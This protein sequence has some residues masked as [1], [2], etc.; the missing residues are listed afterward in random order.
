MLSTDTLRRAKVQLEKRWH[1]LADIVAAVRE[2]G[3]DELSEIDA[4]LQATRSL[5][6]QM[7]K[8]E[9]TQDKQKELVSKSDDQAEVINAQLA[10]S[11]L[12]Q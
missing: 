10:G 9:L 7:G 2:K 12:G 8:Q 1:V 11:K 3:P 6:L 5:L 4:A